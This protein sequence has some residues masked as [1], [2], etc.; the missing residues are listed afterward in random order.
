MGNTISP[1]NSSAYKRTPFGKEMLKHFLFNPNFKNLNHGSHFGALYFE[2]LPNFYSQAP[3]G[4]F[5][6]QFKR[7]R[8]NI[9]TSES[10]LRQPFFLSRL[11][12]EYREDLLLRASPPGISP[13]LPTPPRRSMLT[14]DA[15]GARL[16]PI[17]SSVMNTP[18]YLTC[19]EQQ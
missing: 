16:L 7:N 12:H 13:I 1:D 8:G 15:E 19:H 14:R 11:F 3:L 2:S 5:L 18:K 17:P 4:L 10:D 9:W 6:E